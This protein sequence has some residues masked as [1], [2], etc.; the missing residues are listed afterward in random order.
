MRGCPDYLR[1]DSKIITSVEGVVPGNGQPS[2]DQAPESGQHND[3][4]PPATKPE[5]ATRYS[6][7]SANR[8]IG[9]RQLWF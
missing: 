8:N 3:A 9:W 4:Q 7:V 5:P 6:V 2:N 1:E